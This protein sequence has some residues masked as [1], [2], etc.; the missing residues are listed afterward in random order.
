MPRPVLDAWGLVGEAER[1]DGGQGTSVRVGDLVLK[2]QSDEALVTWH[3][4]LCN[5]VSADAFRL[6]APIPAR[7]GRLVVNGWSASIHVVGHF[8]QEDD[9]TTSSWSSVLVVSRDFHA[10]VSGELRPALTD[11]RADRYARADRAAWDESDSDRVGPQSYPLLHRMRDLTHDEGLP[12][13]LVHGDLSGNVLLAGGYPPAVIDISPYWRPAAYADAVVVI[14]ALLWWGADPVLI[15]LGRPASVSSTQ[16][17][18]LLGRALVFRLLAF[19]ERRRKADEVDDQMPRYA[20]VLDL[21][22]RWS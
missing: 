20:N 17:R 5:R 21:L 16:W 8:V 11:V 15:D 13:Q 4:Q 19:D 12:A 1:L 6:P 3:A 9:G 10:A 2:P 18:S 7:D 14:D 22:A